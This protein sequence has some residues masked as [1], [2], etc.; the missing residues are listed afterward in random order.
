[1]DDQKN[2]VRDSKRYK[3]QVRRMTG[4]KIYD[5]Y[6][7]SFVECGS[8]AF[9][10]LVVQLVID[11]RNRWLD[12]FDKIKAEIEAEYTRLRNMSDRWSERASGLGTALEIID[13]HQPY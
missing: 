10:T 4:M 9:T 3:R 8:D 2:V 5:P 7:D 6:T 1:M 11:E 13:K 12:A